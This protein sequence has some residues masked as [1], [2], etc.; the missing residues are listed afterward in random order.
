MKLFKGV[1]AALVFVILIAGAASTGL[2][3]QGKLYEMAIFEDPTTLNLFGA[4]GPQS[5]VWNDFVSSSQYYVSLYGNAPPTLAFVPIVA[6]DMPGELKEEKIGGKTFYTSIVKM[7]KEFRWSDN[8]PLTA[9]DVV[10]SYNAVLDMDPNKLGGNWPSIVDPTVLERVEKI[11]D[12]TV[13]FILKDK[14][15]LA[16]WQYGLLQHY[17][18]NKKYWEPVFANAKKAADPV[19]ELLAYDPKTEPTAGP[20]K[21]GH[22]EKGAFWQ[23]VPNPAYAGKG[24]TTTFYKNG[25]VTIEN[26]KTGFKWQSGDP[27]GEVLVKIVEG[28][29][30]TGTLYRI[31]QNQSAAVLSLTGGQ[32]DFVLNS[33]GLQR[34]FQE[35]LKKAPNVATIENN[36]NGFRFM[37]F[38]LR[39]YPF[40]IKEFRQAV[41][42]LIDREYICTKVLQGIAFPQYSV[43]PPGNA[44]WFNSEVPALGRGLKRAEKIVKAMELL[45]KVGFK[46][47]VEP[48]VDLEKDKLLQRGKGLIMPDG[49]KMPEFEFMIMTAGY[50]P[51]RYTFGLNIAQWMKDVGIPCEASPTEFNVIATKVFDEQDFDA[52]MMGWSLTVYP[53]HLKSFF[54]SSEAGLGGFNCEGY[55]NPEFDKLADDFIKESDLEK[56]RQKAFKLQEILADE[57]PY[58]V[59]FDT[60]II[61]AYRSDRVEY[62]YTK[63]LS[64]FQRYGALS[65]VVKMLQ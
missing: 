1:L 54:H 12:Y 36:V 60:P 5:T 44:F 34:G 50:D 52:F 38:N 24:D 47:E 41:S 57:L 18:V 17:I 51:L 46:W 14:P 49:K 7:R 40:N 13:K 27:K 8:T 39:K 55:S 63:V 4:V 33:L 15:G 62:P 61:E 32:V 23:N 9:D 11:D 19:K 43:V 28:P 59:L 21:F 64:G 25:A 2:A 56:A 6:L 16:Q 20:W 58:I 42:I 37:A 3:G 45:K 10:F 22:W 29:Y 48:K 31:F 30:A 26:P 53:D 35:Q 65:S